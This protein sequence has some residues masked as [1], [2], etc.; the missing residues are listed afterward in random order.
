VAGES[1]DGDNAWPIEHIPDSDDLYL[2]VHRRWF[3]HE[4]RLDVGCFRNHP[5]KTGGM[6]TDWS[7][8]ADPDQTRRRTLRS[9]PDDNAVIGL[10]VG[11]VRAIPEQTVVHA[12]IQDDLDIPDNCAHTEVFGPKNART[13][14]RFFGAY[15]L[16]IPLDAD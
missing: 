2:R 7:K 5:E 8:Y 12:P 16:L 1:V 4:G 3:D 9:R 13:R 14:T 6:S 15:R 11:A 10:N